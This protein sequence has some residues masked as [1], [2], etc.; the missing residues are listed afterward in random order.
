[1]YL[2]LVL[3][4]TDSPLELDSLASLLR[5][6]SVVILISDQGRTDSAEVVGPVTIARARVHPAVLPD[7]F[8]VTI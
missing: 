4:S 6:G 2:V 1:M 3:L 7:V 8:Q 5:N